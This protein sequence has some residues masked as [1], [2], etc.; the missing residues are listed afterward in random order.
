[1][2]FEFTRSIHLHGFI[3]IFVNLDGFVESILMNMNYIVIVSIY[4]SHNDF[5][6]IFCVN[7]H[8]FMLIY[9]NL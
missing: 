7:L 3:W 5:I 2:L 4:V 9:L 8:T 1:M 6:R